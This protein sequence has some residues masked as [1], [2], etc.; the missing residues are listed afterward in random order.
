MGCLVGVTP[1]VFD[2]LHFLIRNRERVVSKQALIAAIWAGRVVSD[3]ALTTR[4]N[5]ARA[6]VADNGKAQRLI[7]TL[8]RQ[9]IRFVG[10]VREED[11]RVG[12]MLAKVSEDS[13][14]P[15]LAL[16]D[17]P[18]IA[19][20]PF[21][22]TNPG[23]DS[24]Q[25]YF[26]G[27]ITDDIITE[28]SRFSDLFVIARN[29]SFQYRGKVV[30]VREVSRELGVLYVL[31]GAIRR[32]GGRV[33]IAVQL[34]DAL[35]GT[36]RWADRYDRKLDDIF[37][38]QDDVARSIATILAAHVSKAEAERTLLKAPA[39]WQA[40][41]YYLRAVDALTLYWSS[42]K[43]EDVYE[44]RRLIEHSLSIDPNY[45]RAYA[46]LSTTYV[47]AWLNQL[48]S[49]YLNPAALDRAYE[50]ARRAVRLDPNSPQS[51]AGLG[52]VLAWKGQHEL[53]MAEF[54]KAL[55][56]NPNF[57]DWRFAIALVYAGESKRAIRV[58]ETYMRLDPFPAP[59]ALH[60]LG[61]AQFMLKRYL[62]ALPP[63]RDCILRAPNFAAAHV[64]LAASYVRLQRL[65]EA[66]V[67]AAEVLRIDPGFTIDRSVSP[68]LAFK[69][70]RDAE[71]CLAAL[72]RTGLPE[73]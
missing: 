48:D 3:S 15:P 28:L 19:V 71:H 21:T 34:I 72:R 56:L 29:S 54:E 47:I 1:Q 66:R 42:I 16:P 20:L 41:D 65:D 44:A 33:R 35:R 6:A 18:S 31:E 50:L 26:G 12:E 61:L 36:Y 46:L 40:Y 51:H 62:E 5:A 24:D 8:P 55:S 11:E 52:T 39:T 4:I 30:D 23:G 69:Y 17:R 7:K 13:R 70:P 58:L 63:L 10:T 25:D 32:N 57:I 64:W 67:E 60:W 9:G 22:V 14:T 49:D 2:L 37:A 68:I 73:R 38:V 27:G 43:L 45:A 53:S 59:L